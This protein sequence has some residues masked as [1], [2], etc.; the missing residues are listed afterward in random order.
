MKKIYM[1]Y[2]TAFTMLKVA[3]ADSTMVIL[4]RP[5]GHTAMLSHCK[6]II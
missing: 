4:Q 2:G 3:V 6:S 5:S 1:T